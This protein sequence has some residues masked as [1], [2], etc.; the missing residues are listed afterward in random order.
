MFKCT[1]IKTA[2]DVLLITKDGTDAE[3]ST[4]TQTKA[5]EHNFF[6]GAHSTF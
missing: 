2:H 5:G 1:H 6:I 4:L 3:H